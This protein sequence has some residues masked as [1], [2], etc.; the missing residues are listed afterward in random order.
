MDYSEDLM[1]LRVLFSSLK[2]PGTLDI[3]NFIKN[4]NHYLDINSLPKITIYSCVYN[5]EK[6]VLDMIKS[7]LDQTFPDYE[8]IICDDHSKDNSLNII[9]EYISTLH[10]D[11][12]NKIKIIRNQKN[13]GLPASCNKV[14]QMAKGKY[15]VRVDSDDVIKSDMLQKMYDELCI[16]N[17]E[18][19]K[20]AYCETDE[21]LNF[22]K[23]VQE[24]DYHPACCLLAKWAV[25]E[26]KYKEDLQYL[27]GKDFFDR[28]IKFYSITSLQEPLW[29]YRQHNGQKT[30]QADHPC[31]KE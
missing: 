8:F 4:N 20:S 15:I 10:D 3:I 26:L 31:N 9:I 19:V 25:N 12:K 7:V 2:N 6:F 11:I 21:N 13:I 24:N 23:E 1:L 14:L 28:F 17:V 5:H 27:E 22:L 16:N 18:G 29:F 30:K